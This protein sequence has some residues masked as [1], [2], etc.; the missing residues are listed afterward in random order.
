MLKILK[1]ISICV[2]LFG[3]AASAASLEREKATPKAQ[4]IEQDYDEMLELAKQMD[5]ERKP[6]I[7]IVVIS[8]PEIVTATPSKK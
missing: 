4:I 5:Q 7:Y 8:S 6:A 1:Y 2:L 3:C